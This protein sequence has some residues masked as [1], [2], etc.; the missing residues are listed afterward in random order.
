MY[1][2]IDQKTKKA[3][4]VGT[5][6]NISFYKSIG[7][8][9]EEVEQAYNGNYYLKG[10]APTKSTNEQ[11]LEQLE[12]EQKNTLQRINEIKEELI[13]AVLLDDTN[14]ITAL[15]AEYQALIGVENE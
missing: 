3:I 6:S 15:K 5:G 14:T 7:M 1:C 9:D 4:Q 13:T 11:Q 12:Q 2:I 8:T 10:Y